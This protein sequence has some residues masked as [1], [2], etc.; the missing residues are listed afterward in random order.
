MPPRRAGSPVR[1]RPTLRGGRVF[2]PAADDAPPLYRRDSPTW[3]N[4]LAGR[5]TSLR[6]AIAA[7]TERNRGARKYFHAGA[8]LVSAAHTPAS[9]LRK[10]RL[11][12]ELVRQPLCTTSAKLVVAVVV[13][14]PGRGAA[15]AV[16]TFAASCA[17]APVF[18][19]AA[20][21]AAVDPA[22]LRALST[23]LRTRNVVDAVATSGGEGVC[24]ATRRR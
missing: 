6:D 21:T 10:E 15:D 1:R 18:P 8:V 4:W 24:F 20:D 19:D 14:P 17:E 5:E 3:A 12:L 7:M 22:R 23:F 16:E 11:V 2:A 13:T 9:R